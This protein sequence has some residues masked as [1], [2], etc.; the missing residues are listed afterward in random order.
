MAIV[1]KNNEGFVFRMGKIRMCDSNF[2]AL[3]KKATLGYG[4]EDLR[5]HEIREAFNT[6][7][8]KYNVGQ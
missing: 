8:T 6:A 2:D 4:K 1:T 3:L 7:A 5:L